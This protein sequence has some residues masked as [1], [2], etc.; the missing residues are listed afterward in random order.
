[1]CSTDVIAVVGF[2]PWSVSSKG[3]EDMLMPSQS[4]TKKSA[5]GT[6]NIESEFHNNYFNNCINC[7]TTQ[8]VMVKPLFLFKRPPLNWLLVKHCYLYTA[9]Y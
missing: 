6:T 5:V 3:F 4:T 1:M 7:K 8:V 9:T 2:D